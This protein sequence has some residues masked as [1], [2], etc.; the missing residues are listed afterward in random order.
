MQSYLVTIAG[1]L[2]SLGF[3]GYSVLMFGS[4]EGEEF[5]ADSF[6]RREFRYHEVPLLGWQVSPV[7]RQDI[8]ND[9]ES[10]L[11]SA[12]LIGISATQAPQ[13]DLVIARRGGLSRNSNLLS[14]GNARILCQY[15]DAQ[16][17]E[18]Q[19]VWLQWSKER[20]ELAKIVWPAVA[21]LAR[22]ELYIF[23]PDLLVLARGATDATHLQQRM[24]A[25]L[26]DRYI[27]FGQAQQQLSNHQAAIELFTEAL[28]LFP[29]SAEALVGRAKS[30]TTLGMNDKASADLVEAERLGQRH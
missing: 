18:K 15:L 8:T 17:D 20:P 6:T 21:H 30:L 11:K 2:F 23:V 13:W 7:W 29:S 3:I 9:L 26:V 10:Y 24:N 25:H 27:A 5:D 28:A 14:Q 22:Q 19:R 1:V 16:D 4:V 12:K